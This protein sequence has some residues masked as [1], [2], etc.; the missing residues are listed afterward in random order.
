MDWATFFQL[1]AIF[2]FAV[3]YYGLAFLAMRDLIRRPAV[4][5]ENKVVWGLVILCLP[6]VGALFYGYM[7][8][9][10]LMPRKAAAE[11]P[12]SSRPSTDR[13]REE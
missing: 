5:G 10:S 3:I 2:S 6:I 4:R 12:H 11:K 1:V 13:G 9:A 8:A 7:G